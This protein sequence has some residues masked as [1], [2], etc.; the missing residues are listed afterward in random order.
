MPCPRPHFVFACFKRVERCGDWITGAAGPFFVAAAAVLFVLGT[1]CFRT[2]LSIQ[3]YAPSFHKK[4]EPDRVFVVK[5]KLHNQ[6]V[7]II[8]PT[9]PWPWLSVPP[10]ILIIVNLFTHYYFAC[11]VSPGFAG[12]PP[13][14]AGRSFI[15]AKK[16]RTRSRS[17]TNGVSWSSHLN[18]TPASVTKCPKCGDSKYEVRQDIVVLDIVPPLTLTTASQ[19]AHHCRVCKRCVL[20]FDHHCPVRKLLRLSPIRF[21]TFVLA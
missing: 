11:T 1:F 18:I 4:S 12:D 14:H 20:K 8:V 3:F 15:W 5:K 19:R 2:S 9:I 17:L 16:P 21:L 13:Q 6:S 10:C 7:D